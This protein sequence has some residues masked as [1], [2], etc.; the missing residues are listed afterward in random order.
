MVRNSN[1]RKHNASETECFRPQI[2]TPLDSVI[3]DQVIE[4]SS[5]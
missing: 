2:R 3:N 5:F 4:V 1:Y